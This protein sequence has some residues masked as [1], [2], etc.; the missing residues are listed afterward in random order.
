MLVTLAKRGQ[1]AELLSG[2]RKCLFSE[3]ESMLAN[4]G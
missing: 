4:P 2:A 3:I 1:V